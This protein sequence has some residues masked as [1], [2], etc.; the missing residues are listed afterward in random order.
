MVQKRPRTSVA[1]SKLVRIEDSPEFIRSE[2]PKSKR[3]DVFSSMNKVLVLC[4]AFR[5]ANAFLLQTY[6]NPDEHWQA[7]EV[8]HNITFGYGHLTWEWK[9][10]IRSY[11]HPLLFAFLY[12]VLAL[13][14]IDT[15]LLMV[16]HSTTYKLAKLFDWLWQIEL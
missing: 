2:K 5:F 4:L 13:L 16:K 7:L 11:L 3:Y 6:F 9:R 1:A 8:A 15:P 14:G 12:K 10:G